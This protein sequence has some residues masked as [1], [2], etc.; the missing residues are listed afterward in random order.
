M[1][2]NKKHYLIYQITNNIN[3]K[4]Y[5]GKHET[6]NIDDDYFGSGKYLKY[7]IENHG[8]ENFTKTILFELQNREEMNLLEK[9]VV[10]PEFCARKDT[11][12]I[13][14]GGDGGW[15]FINEE[16]D[17]AIGTEKRRQ[18]FHIKGAKSC[19]AKFK[20]SEYGSFTKYCYANMSE[21][22]REQVRQAKS[23]RAKKML[24]S[25]WIG[26]HHTEETKQKI[27]N[28]HKGKF[29]GK[30]NSMFNKVWIK[31]LQLKICII[32]NKD[33]EL[34]NGWEY[35]RCSD[36]E[37]YAQQVAESN[38]Q[39]LEAAEHSKKEKMYKELFFTMFYKFYLKFGYQKMIENFQIGMSQSAFCHMCK[40][41]VEKYSSWKR[42]KK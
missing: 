26:K 5:I 17:F 16:S 27:S 23:Q 28:S 10:T 9:M 38:M 4:F 42:W 21:E 13:N 7:A 14:V 15:Y 33:L 37:K 34:P 3:Q 20:D 6:Y 25:F 30:D 36:F 24:A 19:Q 39:M 32:W 41:Y 35:G 11:Y 8:I 1:N 2:K 22:K 40:K 12:N 18:D 31:N 29:C